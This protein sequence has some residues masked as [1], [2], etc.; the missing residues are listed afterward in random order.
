MQPKQ[1]ASPATDWNA[2][3]KMSMLTEMRRSK[4]IS[5]Q[6]FILQK[7]RQGGP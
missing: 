5:V 1:S 6:S 2:T 7:Y 4:R 3:L